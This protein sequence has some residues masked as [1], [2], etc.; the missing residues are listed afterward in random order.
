MATGSF[1]GCASIDVW[2]RN[3]YD[4][5]VSRNPAQPASNGPAGDVAPPTS[6]VSDCKVRHVA[7]CPVASVPGS[8]Q[9]GGAAVGLQD[10]PRTTLVEYVSRRVGVHEGDVG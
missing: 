4:W 1:E 9:P 8:S 2:P 10:A 3:L 7:H 6:Q 5:A